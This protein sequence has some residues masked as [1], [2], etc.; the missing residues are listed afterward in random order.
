MGS[1]ASETLATYAFNVDS[2]LGLIPERT[3]AAGGR[4]HSAGRSQRHGLNRL[5]GMG[6]S[7][8]L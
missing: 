6:A 2:A 1:D 7:A 4:G 5:R 8:L 3:T